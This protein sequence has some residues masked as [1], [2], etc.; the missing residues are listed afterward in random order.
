MDKDGPCGSCG[1]KVRQLPTSIICWQP[2]VEM[3]PQVVE[4]CFNGL[5]CQGKRA[6]QVLLLIDNARPHSSKQS[7]QKVASLGYTVLPHLPYSPDL[8][9]S[10]YALFNKMKEPLCGRKFPT[11]GDLERGVRDSVCTVPKNWYPATIQKLPERWQRFI[12]LGEEYVKS[13]TV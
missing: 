10:D 5:Q 7:T 9:L 13:A 1:R 11:S 3:L 4:Q 8:A 2:C 6:Y 12:D